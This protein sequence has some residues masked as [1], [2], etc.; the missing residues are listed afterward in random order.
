MDLYLDLAEDPE[1][2]EDFFGAGKHAHSDGTAPGVDGTRMKASNFARQVQGECMA[3]IDFAMIEADPDTYDQIND[4]IQAIGD[5]HFGIELDA[6]AYTVSGAESINNDISVG[7]LTVTSTGVLDTNGYK[8]FVAGT[9]TIEAGGV[10][11]NDGSA[12]ADGSSGGAG[13]AGASSGSLLGGGNGAN[14]LSNGNGSVGTP[15]TTSGGGAGGQGGN[16]NGINVGGAGGTAAAPVAAMGLWSR[17]ASALNGE[18]RGATT[19]AFL[20]GGAGGGSGASNG[21]IVTSG[22]GGGGAGVVVIWA[23]RLINNGVIR[24]K[25]G[26]GGIGQGIGGGGGG[27]G[28]GLIF[29]VAR[30]R[31][32]TATGTVNV[33][34]GVGGTSAGGG[35][36]GSSGSAGTHV[37]LTA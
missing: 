26:A 29:T 23:K 12:G 37:E 19:Q 1:A 5:G 27:G 30:Y 36:T 32:P 34:G 24:A 20:R 11:S 33:D 21:G 16:D 18:V 28:G 4:A 13:G 17:L 14:G 15:V 31:D 10:I 3:I 25:G 9:L 7:D 8:V 6:P 35:A 2:E 22:G